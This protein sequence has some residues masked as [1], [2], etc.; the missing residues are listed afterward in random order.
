MMVTPLS[1]SR[2]DQL[3]HV[4]AQLDVDAG[5]RLVEEQDFGLVAERLGD[6]HPALHAA[7]QLHDLGLAL[8]PQRQ[9][10]QHLLDMRR[11]GRLPNR[12][13]LKL[14]VAQH[15]SKASVCSSC[16]T[17]PILRARRAIVAADVVAVDARPSPAVGV[18][19]PQTMLIRVVLPA[20]LGPSRAKISPLRD[21]EVDVL[22][23]LDAGRV[24]LG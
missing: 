9:V 20:P 14:T 13:R 17:R 12:P 3:P 15:V 11:V 24:G 10:A 8:V 5:G 19:M 18:T 7:R 6:H 21:V 1:R 4:A 16:G 23:R 22:Q 2:A